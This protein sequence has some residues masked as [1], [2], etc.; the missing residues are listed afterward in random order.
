MWICLFFFFILTE[1]VKTS[2]LSKSEIKHCFNDSKDSNCKNILLFT[3]TL[4]NN[5]IAGTE[6]AKF[7]F[8]NFTD[9]NNHQIAL[10]KPVTLEVSKS[11]VKVLYRLKYIRHFNGQA[12]ERIIDTIW[13]FCSEGL[14]NSEGAITT[15]STC[16]YVLNG[17][18]PVPYSQGFC[19]S[20]DA[21]T[22]L[23]GLSDDVTRGSCG[24]FSSSETAHCLEFSDIYFAGYEIVS[25]QFGYDIDVTLKYDL[26]GIEKEIKETITVNRRAFDN[27]IVHAKII[28]DFLPSINPPDI[29]NKVLFVPDRNFNSTDSQTNMT[30]STSISQEEHDISAN[31]IVVER[32]LVSFS[33]DECDK[34]GVGYKAFHS[35][36]NRCDV[37]AGTCIS[38]QILDLIEKDKEKQ[39]SSKPTDFLLKDK[40]NFIGITNDDDFTKLELIFEDIFTTL[41]SIEIEADDFVFVTNL[42]KASIV[43]LEVKDFEA[44]KELGQLLAQVKNTGDNK[45]EFEISVKC[46][47]QL[48]AVPSK[49][50]SMDTSETANIKFTFSSFT[51]LEAEHVCELF[52]SN[53]RGKI[54]D[55][56]QVS[57][58]T[59][60]RQIETQNAVD[61]EEDK[62]I[63]EE[64]D[65]DKVQEQSLTEDIIC[66]Y[67]C[68]DIS[69]AACFIIFGCSGQ[70]K[71][72]VYYIVVV[73]ILIPL[74][75]IVLWRV[76]K[77]MCPCLSCCFGN[78]KRKGYVDK[79]KQCFEDLT[80][81]ESKKLS[82]FETNQENN[83]AKVNKPKKRN[84]L[85]I[86][87]S[88]VIK[89]IKE[90]KRND[91][92]LK[93]KKEQLKDMLGFD[94]PK[95]LS[96]KSQKIG[97]INDQSL[98][99]YNS[100]LNSLLK[101][102][103]T[104]KESD[105]NEMVK[106]CI[107]NDIIDVIMIK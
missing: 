44:Q 81:Q 11:L 84:S 87:E 42:G 12:R 88:K 27:G 19:C 96:F 51:S 100:E 7:V 10:E 5:Q 103:F 86:N 62:I 57:F 106:R 77:C 46:S 101:E 47:D 59:F 4:E 78:N 92:Y 61:Q 13:P 29:V 15:D 23:T 60:L 14:I 45:A 98:Y 83:I 72:L 94:I 30:N 99:K 63:R 25:Y 104:Q 37:E 8:K 26:N 64:N 28:G 34:I 35:Q 43:S 90:V 50:I 54:V 95:S 80:F 66:K 89:T 22:L 105:F 85:S 9:T 20:C 75:S 53:S 16:G 36:A 2:I 17:E 71:R 38:N 74:M 33:G 76:C 82:G 102:I 97:S 93:L 70:I 55:S 58:K 24:L 69:N 31:W 18:E 32:D 3:L 1:L 49:K 40:G 107:E 68:P 91:V 65:K 73:I 6:Y 79:P 52:V 39:E 67:L 41:V 48:E 56:K 21:I